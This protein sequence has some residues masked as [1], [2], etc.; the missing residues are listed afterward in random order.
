MRITNAQSLSRRRA[1]LVALAMSA[2]FLGPLNANPAAAGETKKLSNKIEVP[3]KVQVSPVRPGG[4][5]SLIPENFKPSQ[6]KSLLKRL[7]A[8]LGKAVNEAS[9]KQIVAAIERLWLTSGSD[10]VDFLMSNAIGAVEEKD[11]DV[12]E[13][14]LS[15]IIELQPEYTEA[16]NKRAMVF[17]MRKDFNKAIRDLRRFGI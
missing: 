4:M 9:G 17:F 11:L 16:W 3:E 14:I 5:H 15:R 10:T 8:R 12:A 2:L 7:Y 6:K 13:E 1:L